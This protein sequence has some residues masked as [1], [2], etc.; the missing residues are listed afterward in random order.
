MEGMNM[1]DF[2]INITIVGLGLIGGSYAMAIKEL[3][4]RNIWGVDIDQDALHYAEEYGIIDHGYTNPALPLSKSDLVIICLYPSATIDF[5]RE[6]LTNFKTGSIITDAAGVKERL[7]QEIAE[8][9]PATL[10]FIGGHPMTG[11]EYSGIRYAMGDLFLGANYILTPTAQND[12]K[13]LKL[14]EQLA[15]LIGCQNVIRVKP[16]V[17]DQFI[18]YTSQLPHLIANALIDGKIYEQTKYFV[19]G[20]FSDATRVAKINLELWPELLLENS[21]NLLESIEQFEYNLQA[22]KEAIVLQDKNSLIEIFARGNDK[23]DAIKG[24]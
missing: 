10:Q 18:A 8:I 11:R 22:L 19:G 1:K 16:Q 4:P 7:L 9:L 6:N 20:S 17:H 12:E 13:S 5:V 2:D 15:I 3:N 21:V 24:N 23:N 14:I